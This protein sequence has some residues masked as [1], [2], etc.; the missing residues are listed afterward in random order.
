MAKKVV[1]EGIEI[2]PSIKLCNGCENITCGCPAGWECMYQVETQECEYPESLL[3][4]Y[5]AVQQQNAVDR[6][7]P[8]ESRA[9][10][11]TPGN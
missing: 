10:S 11:E 5:R 7:T 6:V 1:V 8:D 4:K 3:A 2:V 9:A